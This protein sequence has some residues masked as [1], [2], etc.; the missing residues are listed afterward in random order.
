MV[1]I[2]YYQRLRDIREDQ[3]K[4]QDE[5]AEYLETTRQQYSRWENGS[6]QTPIEIYKKLARYYNLSIDYLSGLIDEPNT[7]SEYKKRKSL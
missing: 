5:I 7:I 4:T 6:Y 2:K 3:R 1:F